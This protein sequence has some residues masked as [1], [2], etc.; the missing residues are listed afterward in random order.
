EF[1]KRALDLIAD[2]N[3]DSKSSA[4]YVVRTDDP[5]VDVVAVSA[6]LERFRTFFESVFYK[7]GPVH[8]EGPPVDVLLFY[9][10]YKYD[11]LYA[12]VSGL[13]SAGAIGHYRPGYNVIAIHSDAVDPGDLP[14]VISHEAAHQLILDLLYGPKPKAMSRWVNEGL[15]SYFG[16]TRMDKHGEFHDG[17]IGGQEVQNLRDVPAGRA[18]EPRARLDR[19]RKLAGKAEPG[20]VDDLVRE[21]MQSA[22]YSDDVNDRYSAAWLLVHFLLHGEDGRLAGPFR[23]YIS[24]EARGEVGADAFYKTIGVDPAKLEA[25]LTAYV[26]KLKAR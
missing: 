10:R 17:E 24:M 18:K 9:S 3:Y 11:R 16:F 2:R 4:H 5:R 1:R 12:D 14:G 8:H 25:E 13:G 20:F 22:F 19:F 6:F 26:K 21:E 15:A 23:E 7:P